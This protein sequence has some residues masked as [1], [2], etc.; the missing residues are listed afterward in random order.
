MYSLLYTV[1]TCDYF[2]HHHLE[3]KLVTFT[4]CVATSRSPSDWVVT[5]WVPEDLQIILSSPPAAHQRCASLSIAAAKV[6]KVP[7]S[8]G[9]GNVLTAIDFNV[10]TFAASPWGGKKTSVAEGRRPWSHLV[11]TRRAVTSEIPLWHGTRSGE[12]VWMLT[13]AYQWGS[14]HCY[15][16]DNIVKQMMLI[17]ISSPPLQQYIFSFSHRLSNTTDG[18]KILSRNERFNILNNLNSL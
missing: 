18:S 15:V 16:A 7:R 12:L 13:K 10:S 8:I 4:V 6:V 11:K 3:C 2:S 17:F 14:G 1:Q 9:N 5:G